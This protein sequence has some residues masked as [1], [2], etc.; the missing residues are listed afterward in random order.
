MVDLYARDVMAIP[1]RE[2]G[3]VLSDIRC[4]KFDPDA[5]ASSRFA[6]DAEPAVVEVVPETGEQEHD[7]ES[8]SSIG[9]TDS[10]QV[11]EDEVV[12]SPSETVDVKNGRIAVHHL[13][14]DRVTLRCGKPWP[15]RAETMA[16]APPGAVLCMRCF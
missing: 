16:D 8:L 7:L 11:S 1:L 15:T 12:P 4:G 14:D 6:A 9:W 13:A 10:E 5:S 2:M 3:K